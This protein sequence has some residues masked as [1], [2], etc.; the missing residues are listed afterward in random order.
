M[1]SLLGMM[2]VWTTSIMGSSR[3]ISPFPPATTQGCLL[4]SFSVSLLSG[5]TSIIPRRRFW[6]SGGTKWGMWKTPR[7]TWRWLSSEIL[8]KRFEWPSLEVVGDYHRRMGGLR[9]GERRGSHRRTRRLLGSRHI[10]LPVIVITLTFSS[11]TFQLASLCLE[12]FKTRRRKVL[13]TRLL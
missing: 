10:S 12:S 11:S 4:T 8:K 6:Q 2:W 3:S 13:N 5:L 7:F 9:P 1:V